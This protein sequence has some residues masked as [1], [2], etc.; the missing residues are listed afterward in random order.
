MT[1]QKKIVILGAS[2]MVGREFLDLCERLSLRDVLAPGRNEC[3]VV[4]FEQV[5]D[6]LSVHTPDVI[7]NCTGI[8]D[9]NVCEKKPEFAH[10]VNAEGPRN[11]AQAM[12]DLQM[13]EA[14]MLHVSTC[15]VF[16]NDKQEYFESDAPGP[17][18]MYGKTKLAGEQFIESILRNSNIAYYIIRTSWIYSQY[19]D[20][21][22]DLVVKTLRGGQSIEIVTDQFNTVTWAKDLT[23]ACESFILKP[24]I[25]ESGVYHVCAQTERSLSK[26]EIALACAEVCSL[27]EELLIPAKSSDLLMDT[28]PRSAFLKTSKKIILPRWK[29][30]LLDYLIERYG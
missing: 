16:G 12:V 2:G 20:T 1:P 4:N 25:F 13:T 17:L 15:Y 11:I 6:Y 3:D 28:R 10:S 24:D 30:S 14:I 29:D 23:G 18:N 22:V 8:V 9:L 5:R 7:I 26:M 21:F 27:P 19:K